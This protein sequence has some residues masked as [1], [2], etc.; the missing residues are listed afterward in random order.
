LS[1]LFSK[2]GGFLPKYKS[3]NGILGISCKFLIMKI[4]VS[5]Y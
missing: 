5:T 2:K 4:E 1:I 3:E